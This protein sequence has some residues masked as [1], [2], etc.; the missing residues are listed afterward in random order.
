[1]VDERTRVIRDLLQRL[2]E[3][4]VD[5]DR[6]FQATFVPGRG[7][8]FENYDESASSSSSSAGTGVVHGTKILPR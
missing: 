4:G 3:A 1:M 2:A 5:P 8:V 6:P 7:W